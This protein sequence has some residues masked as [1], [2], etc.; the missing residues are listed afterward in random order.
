M[1]KYTFFSFFSRPQ[2]P[3]IDIYQIIIYTYIISDSYVV[4]NLSFFQS[5]KALDGV[6]FEYYNLC[7]QS[8]PPFNCCTCMETLLDQFVCLSAPFNRI[9][10]YF[11]K[12][13]PN[14]RDINGYARLKCLEKFRPYFKKGLKENDMM[15]LIECQTESHQELKFSFSSFGFKNNP[16]LQ[17]VSKLRSYHKEWRRLCAGA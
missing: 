10:L 12:Q 3:E 4:I 13:H 1:L 6:S 17:L 5:L 7:F 14:H 8:C 9:L 15:N 11:Y 16:F 2:E